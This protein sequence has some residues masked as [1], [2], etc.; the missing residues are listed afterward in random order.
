MQ[1]PESV[2]Y[3]PKKRITCWIG[4]EQPRGRRLGC[5]RFAKIDWKRLN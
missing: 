4:A 5:A 2:S 3:F 1:K